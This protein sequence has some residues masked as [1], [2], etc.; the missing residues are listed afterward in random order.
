MGD[1][2]EDL[3]GDGLRGKKQVRVSIEAKRTKRDPHSHR[4]LRPE[5]TWKG[6]CA[7][8]SSP[9]REIR[10]THSACLPPESASPPSQSPLSLSYGLRA[11]RP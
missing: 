2:G 11:D 8:E 9:W 10:C 1:G 7:A 5:D 3:G 4:Q 6:S